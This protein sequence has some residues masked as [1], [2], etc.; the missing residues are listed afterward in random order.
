MSDSD[1]DSIP[2]PEINFALVYAFHTFVATVDGQASVMRG[3][4]LVLLDDA[5]SYWWL[6]RVL[7]TDEVGY[8][9][10]E[11]VETP[12]ERLARLNKWRNVEVSRVSSEARGKSLERSENQCLAP[13]ATSP[14]DSSRVRRMPRERLVLL[15]SPRP[16]PCGRASLRLAS[17]R[18]A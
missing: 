16:P 6:V 2:D 5:N 14:K 17:S 4:S 12:W 10:A 3:D 1:S 8:I 7:K 9:P 11:N 18:A 13:Q 15:A